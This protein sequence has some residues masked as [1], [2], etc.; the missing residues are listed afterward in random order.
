MY[1]ITRAI[2]F[3]SLVLLV[4]FLFLKLR[5]KT[6]RLIESGIISEQNIAKYNKVHAKDIMFAFLA[7]FVIGL[8]FYAVTFPIEQYFL[9]FDSEKDAFNYILVNNSD[10][11]KYE[12]DDCIFYVDSTSHV[13]IYG[14]TKNDDKFSYVDYKNKDINYN[15]H[16]SLEDI[17]FSGT[18]FNVLTTDITAKYNEENDIT[19][20]Y[21]TIQGLNDSNCNEVTLN[22]Q[23][24]TLIKTYEYM[25][26][27]AGYEYIKYYYTYFSDGTPY[28]NI[29]ILAGDNFSTLVK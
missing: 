10:L 1:Y 23:P 6:E 2:I 18:D 20:Y 12:K 16:N 27:T 28:E 9:S 25:K 15:V 21:I 14:L 3:I 8:V 24:L 7:V 26:P 19:F 17:N 22:D 11:E 13:K 29:R 4:I 5:K